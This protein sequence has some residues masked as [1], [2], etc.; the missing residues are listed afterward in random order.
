VLLLYLCLVSFPFLDITM[1]G[2]RSVS[3]VR[4]RRGAA[5]PELS[6]ER[7]S[8]EID[9]DGVDPER[10]LQ[11]LR[12]TGHLGDANLGPSGS[13]V[14]P[15]AAV[16]DASTRAL[17]NMEAMFQRLLAQAPTVVSAPSPPT[18]P[19]ASAS[20][21]STTGKPHLKFPDPPTFEGDPVKL[22]GWLTQTEMF[23]KA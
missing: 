19:S 13:G 20:T 17:V 22:D 9:L 5:T 12:A 3:R 18:A 21:T 7:I 4:T 15:Q 1:S 14:P 8:R 11:H 6:P 2:R 16:D 10:M 23:L